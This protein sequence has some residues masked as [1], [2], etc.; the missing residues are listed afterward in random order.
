MYV[1]LFFDWVEDLRSH[2]IEDK[3]AIEK[4][5][6]LDQRKEKYQIYQVEKKPIMFQLVT[7]N[8][9]HSFIHS[10]IYLSLTLI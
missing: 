10:P 9:L 2:G 6:T 5:I 7:K 4:N 8:T 3:C 1:T